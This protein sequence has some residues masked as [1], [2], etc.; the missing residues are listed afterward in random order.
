[1]A[2]WRRSRYAITYQGDNIGNPYYPLG[3]ARAR[4]S[5]GSANYW[6]TDLGNQ[7]LGARLRPLDAIDFEERDWV[8][9]SG[10][11]NRTLAGEQ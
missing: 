4:F 9:Y 10:S 11:S 3:E 1:M 5:G 2:T 6:E 8:P 7:R